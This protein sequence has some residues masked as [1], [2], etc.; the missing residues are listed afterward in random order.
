QLFLA[1]LVVDDQP[2]RAVA[3]LGIH[4]VVPEVERLQDMTIG[5]DDVVD[6]AH[7]APPPVGYAARMLSQ[8]VV[9]RNT[10]YRSVCRTRASYMRRTMAGVRWA[11]DGAPSCCIA[12]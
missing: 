7:R 6:A 10:E 3:E 1:G 9:R 2:R 12:A 4:V 8:P 11:S 5:V